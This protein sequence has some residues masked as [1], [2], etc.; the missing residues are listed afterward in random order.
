MATVT[1]NYPNNNNP[2]QPQMRDGPGGR[3]TAVDMPP[4]SFS[5][6]KN[7]YMD[8]RSPQ[9]FFT[10]SQK[11][12]GVFCMSRAT[13]GLLVIGLIVPIIMVIIGSLY[14]Y[15]CPVERYIPIYLIVAGVLYLMI[16]L[17]GIFHQ[18]WH[19]VNPQDISRHPFLHSEACFNH[20][21]ANW[22]LFA[23]FIAGSVWVYRVLWPSFTMGSASYCHPVL[24][25]FA[26]TIISAEWVFFGLWF[27]FCCGCCGLACCLCAKNKK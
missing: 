19:A 11:C 14:L 8:I 21:L 27:I 20:C 23:W 9:H 6:L 3:M 7:E 4:S 25:K 17:S 26:L 1:V 18:I 16:L 15:Q 13:L 22:F 24:Y 12:C 5:D 2:A 10:V